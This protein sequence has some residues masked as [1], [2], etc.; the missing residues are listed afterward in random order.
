MSINLPWFTQFV[1]FMNW[2]NNVNLCKVCKK[3]AQSNSKR[4][5]CNKVPLSSIWFDHFLNSRV[6]NLQIFVLLFGKFKT[7]K[8]HS[9]INWPLNVPR[10][11]G[12]FWCRFQF[13]IWFPKL[14]HTHRLMCGSFHIQCDLISF[15]YRNWS[16]TFDVYLLFAILLGQIYQKLNYRLTNWPV[17]KLWICK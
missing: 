9:E 15:E 17:H 5:T 7:Y 2:Q 13:Q 14:P 6:E 12:L 11:F 4:I 10:G 3:I 1:Q 8:S 16:Q